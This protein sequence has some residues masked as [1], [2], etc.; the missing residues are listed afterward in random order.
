V[1]PSMLLVLRQPAAPSNE[2]LVACLQ[3]HVNDSWV[4][5]WCK[6]HVFKFSGRCKELDMICR[7]Y[8]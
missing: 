8:G 3:V 5:S 1:G 6:L 2:G 7:M 4:A